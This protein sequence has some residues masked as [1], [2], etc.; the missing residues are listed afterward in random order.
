MTFSK[1][2]TYY[3]LILFLLFQVHIS[4]LDFSIW[5][6]NIIYKSYIFFYLYSILFFKVIDKK[7]KKNDHLATFFFIGST[8][9]LV[10]FYFIFRPNLYQVNLIDKLNISFF[11]IP[12]IF[13]SVSL[14]YCLSK[15]LTKTN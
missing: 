12:Y 14:I 10:L 6:F 9:K 15:L 8:T 7:I 3:T 5:N 4:F 13:S 2:T 1:F 11:L